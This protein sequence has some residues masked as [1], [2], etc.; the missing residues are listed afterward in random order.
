MDKV[1]KV[2]KILFNGAGGLSD[3]WLVIGKRFGIG[4][5]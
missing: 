1:M 3:I 4:L 2:Y 5:G